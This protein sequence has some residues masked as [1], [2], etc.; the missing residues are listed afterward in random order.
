MV[1]LRL[2]VA[3]PSARTHENRVPDR[4]RRT[5]CAVEHMSSSS[6]TPA[7]GGRPESAPS[8]AGL[9]RSSQISDGG[10]GGGGGGG[11]GGGDA[12]GAS[13]LP[14]PAV[15]ARVRCEGLT[16]AAELNGRLGRVVRHEGARARV[17]MDHR[18]RS[19]NVKPQNLVVVFELLN[20]LLEVPGLN[21]AREVLARLD[22]TDRALLAQVGRP[23][24]AA[25]VS[26][27]LPRAGKRGA[28]PLMLKDVVVSVELL[29]WAKANGCQW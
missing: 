5:S 29:A 6:P 12:R 27:G 28:V 17:L 18:G 24:L 1:A 21:F 15:G 20:R 2:F 19:V 16:G 9:S 13:E 22:P 4:D 23:W 26:S 7:P 25:V 11:D 8:L 10:G 3:P 14:L